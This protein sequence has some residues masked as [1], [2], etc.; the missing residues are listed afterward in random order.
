M[1]ALLDFKPDAVRDLAG[2]E[3]G[4]D[5]RARV[6]AG[7][8]VFEQLILGVGGVDVEEIGR[9]VQGDA[10]AGL[11]DPRDVEDHFV[12][13]GVGVAVGAPFVVVGDVVAVGVV[14]IG[15]QR[16]LLELEG[17][18]VVFEQHR[19]IGVFV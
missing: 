3:P 1:A 5:A 6:C 17:E 16:A 11:V 19:G 10:G 14:V 13:V 7:D 2:V 12:E 15:D 9:D 8:D 4:E 18:V